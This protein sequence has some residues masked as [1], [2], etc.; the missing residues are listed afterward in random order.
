VRGCCGG[1]CNSKIR[2]ETRF[3]DL[4]LTFPL[5]HSAVVGESVESL[6]R[7]ANEWQAQL[8]GVNSRLV[9]GLCCNS[10]MSCVVCLVDLIRWE[11][12]CVNVGGKLG[13]ERCSNPA[14]SIEVNTAEELVCLDLISASPAQTVLSI[15]NEAI[16][17]ISF[18]RLNSSSIFSYLRIKFSAS[19]PN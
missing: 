1:S 2:E 12:G 11:V 19:G 5:P 8:R 14:Q 15:A 7:I 6:E 17:A 4:N 13:L 18:K 3:P 16:K 10:H 9:T